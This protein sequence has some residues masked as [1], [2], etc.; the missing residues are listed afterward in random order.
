MLL[1]PSSPSVRPES[2]GRTDHESRVTLRRNAL[3]AVSVPWDLQADPT[4][5]GLM[6]TI[7]VYSASADAPS[8]GQ[9][10]DGD[11]GEEDDHSDRFM[12][13][14]EQRATAAGSPLPASPGFLGSSL[15]YAVDLLVSKAMNQN[16]PINFRIA[17]L[18]DLQQHLLES[19]NV[20]KDRLDTVIEALCSCKKP[21]LAVFR[22]LS[23]EAEAEYGLILEPI[24]MYERKAS[25][26]WTEGAIAF[27]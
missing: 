26:R 20:G 27:Q 16:K 5:S 21:D 17:R 22:Q 25:W 1:T 8:G 24:E 10:A 13:L 12:N 23:S 11:S 4:A 3:D 14:L 7:S 15:F 19:E 6:A 2:L 18:R 9:G